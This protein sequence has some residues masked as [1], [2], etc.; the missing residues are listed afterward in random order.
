M[1]EMCPQGADSTAALDT[2]FEWIES[3]IYFQLTPRQHKLQSNILQFFFIFSPHSLKAV[4]EKR[5]ASNTRNS[6]EA[7]SYFP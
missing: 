4:I 1:C 5:N 6:Q 2:R 7:V 3:Q